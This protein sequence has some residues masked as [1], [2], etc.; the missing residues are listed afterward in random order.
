MIHH[1]TQ[2][3]SNKKTKII[4]L[5]ESLIILCVVLCSVSRYCHCYSWGISLFFKMGGE[6]EVEEGGR[7]EVEPVLSDHDLGKRQMILGK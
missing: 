7:G 3:T 4:L 2:Q 1:Q 6:G 5:N